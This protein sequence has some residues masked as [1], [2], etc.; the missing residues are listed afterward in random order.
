MLQETI[1][2]SVCFAR[3]VWPDLVSLLL[4]ASWPLVYAKESGRYAGP[5][6]M[7]WKSK[8]ETV[9]P[10]SVQSPLFDLIPGRKVRLV[11]LRQVGKPCFHRALPTPIK[12]HYENHDTCSSVSGSKQD[13]T[14]PQKQV[15]VVRL[16]SQAPPKGTYSIILL[17]ISYTS[18]VRNK[19]K[20]SS[21]KTSTSISY[22]TDIIISDESL[23]FGTGGPHLSSN[24]PAPV[25]LRS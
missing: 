17:V 15:K 11:P 16:P 10:L 22:L 5:H 21:D 23:L 4:L 24:L 13:T 19:H 1:S 2:L 7:C 12:N 8:I 25:N 14:L 9:W 18:S 3:S 6:K 20:I